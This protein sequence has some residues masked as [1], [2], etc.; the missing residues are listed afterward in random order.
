LLT[1]ELLDKHISECKQYV[2]AGEEDPKTLEFFLSLRH[3]LE[4]AT[5]EDWTAYNEL[6]DHLPKEDAD[7]VLIILKGH[8]LIERLVRKFILSRLPNSEA[9]DKANFNAAQCIVLAESMCLKNKEPEWLWKQVKEINTIR[10]KLAHNLDYES[11]EPRIK[12]FVS[13]ISNAQKLENR[14]ITSAISRLYGMLKG[15]C[16]L[17]QSEGF[18][19]YKI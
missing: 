12:N 16:D 19:G 6:V 11:V 14:T 9:F 3:D 13:T 17:S 2:E 4:N 15:L 7:P 18:R 5:P 10:N 1:P 8:L